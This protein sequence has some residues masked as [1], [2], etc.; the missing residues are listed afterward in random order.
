MRYCVQ[1]A[2]R[3]EVRPP[4]PGAP[5]LGQLRVLEEDHVVVGARSGDRV[6]HELERSLQVVGL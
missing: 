5:V 6:P 1:N 4:A 3:S 2:Q